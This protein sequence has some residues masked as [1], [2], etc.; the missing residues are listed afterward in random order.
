MTVEQVRVD[1]IP[2]IIYHSP[3]GKVK[4]INARDAEI[5]TAVRLG[6][7]QQLQAAIIPDIKKRTNLGVRLAKHGSL[8]EAACSPDSDLDMLVVFTISAGY[9][10]WQTDAA[11]FFFTQLLRDNSS[12][13]DRLYGVSHQKI[14]LDFFEAY[15]D[16]STGKTKILQF[17][18]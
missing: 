6:I 5:A 11:D 10:S 4:Q 13:K 1:G 16:E 9:P 7:Y 15:Y 8:A 3:H 2:Y 12:D 14:W 18:D 17:P